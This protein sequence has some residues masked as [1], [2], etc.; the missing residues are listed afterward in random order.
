MSD[1][2]PHPALV[3]ITRQRENHKRLELLHRTLEIALKQGGMLSLSEISVQDGE[4]MCHVPPSVI[5]PYLDA[6]IVEIENCIKV[7]AVLLDRVAK[8]LS[9]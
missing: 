8:L 6:E 3:L 7:N 1:F 2:N 4:W 9:E 5:V